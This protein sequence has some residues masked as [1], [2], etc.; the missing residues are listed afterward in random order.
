[1]KSEKAKR[2]NELEEE[3]D[4]LKRIVA[5]RRC[6]FGCRTTLSSGSQNQPLWAE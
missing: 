1:M 5:D 2:L 3:N 6:T 4:H